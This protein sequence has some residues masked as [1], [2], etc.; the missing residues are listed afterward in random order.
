MIK[1]IKS[2]EV[3]KFISD[4]TGAQLL[5]VRTPEEWENVGKPDGEKLG[6]KTHFAT[7]S[8]GSDGKVS[9]DFLDTVKKNINKDKKLLVICQAGGRSMLASQIL[10]QEGYECLNISDG[11]EGNGI[12]PGWKNE[13]LPSE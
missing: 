2:S 9:Q 6:I 13:G 11:F 12:N 4:N 3:K 8:R 7:I 1:Q 10:F 5:D